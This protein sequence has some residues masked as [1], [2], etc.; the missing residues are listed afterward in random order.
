MTIELDTKPA[1]VVIDLQAAVVALPSAHPMDQVIANAASLADA[2]RAKGLPVV[3]VNV[4]GRAPGR[5][6]R[7]KA[8]GQAAPAAFP[9]EATAIVPELH[10]QPTDLRVTKQTLGAFLSTNL[11]EQ[12]QALGVD[13]I[14]LVGVSTTSGVES[15]ARSAYELG[16]TVGFVVDGMTDMSIDAHDASVSYQFPKLGEIGTTNEVLEALNQR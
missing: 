13:Q 14:L 10:P 16:Y 11:H 2:F 15:T 5:T 12:L 4:D 6:E 9:A 1:L 7:S 3:L 8:A